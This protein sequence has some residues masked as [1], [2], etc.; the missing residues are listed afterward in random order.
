MKHEDE[1]GDHLFTFF[2]ELVKR[3]VVWSMHGDIYNILP[4]IPYNT[5]SLSHLQDTSL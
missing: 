3:I 1:Q 4:P 5:A 2:T